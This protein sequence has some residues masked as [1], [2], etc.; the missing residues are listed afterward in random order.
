MATIYEVSKAAGVSLATVSRVINKNAA[1]SPK[2][3]EKVEQAM[4]ELGYRPNTIAQSLASSKSNSVGVLVSELDSPFFGEMMSGIETELRSAGKQVIFAAGHNTEKVEKESIEF[5]LSRFCDALIIHIEQTPNDYLVELSKGKVPVYLINRYLEPLK[6]RCVYMN[7]ELGGYRATKFAID[8]GH[9][10][11]A[12]LCGP[13]YK[14]DAMERLKGYQRALEE[15]GID[16][17]ESLIVKGDYSE[18]SGSEQFSILYQR[19]QNFSALVCGNDEMASGAMKEARDLGL[20]IPRAIS[21]IGFDNTSF[22]KY[23][24]PQ[25]TTIDNPVGEMGKMAAKLVLNEVYEQKHLVQHYFEPE[26]VERSSVLT[27]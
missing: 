18:R 6:Q 11:I 25:L 23:L 16:Y 5:L 19:T 3:R 14:D 13:E 4:V 21:I 17:D 12:Y 26:L 27:V 24:Y 22:A 1:V 8:K 10:N 2:T 7:N 15:A 9:K 20:D